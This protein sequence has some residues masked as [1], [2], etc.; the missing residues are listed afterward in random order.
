MTSGIIG[1][2]LA[3]DLFAFLNRIV[4]SYTQQPPLT[5]YLFSF[6]QSPPQTQ[7][8]I[9][10]TH[11]HAS[12]SRT[13]AIRRVRDPPVEAFL[14]QHRLTRQERQR[15]LLTYSA[16]STHTHRRSHRRA[17]PTSLRARRSLQRP[18][19][20]IGEGGRHAQVRSA[21]LTPLYTTRR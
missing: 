21:F 9:S 7:Q 5:R 11:N 1:L 15:Y 3:H 13:T 12:P 14:R 2:R 4:H 18:L 10:F 17:Q 20:V 6:L 8:L 19:K 16:G